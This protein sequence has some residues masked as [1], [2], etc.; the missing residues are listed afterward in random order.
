MKTKVTISLTRRQKQLIKRIKGNQGISDFI[1]YLLDRYESNTIY[2]VSF[3][4][5]M[6]DDD[7][8]AAKE[9]YRMSNEFISSVHNNDH[10][11]S[12]DSIAESIGEVDLDG[13]T[14]QIQIGLVSKQ[15]D[16][17][18]PNSIKTVNNESTLILKKSIL[19]I[20]KK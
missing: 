11:L 19:N 13:K 17:I 7:M 1:G 4:S 6:S 12:L 10:L 3:E 2:P 16:F 15:C 5:E 9:F 20:N 18:H 8:N 14:F